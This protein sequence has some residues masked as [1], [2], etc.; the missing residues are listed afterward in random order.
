VMKTSSLIAEK[1]KA[2]EMAL[3]IDGGGG[4]YDEAGKPEYF[5]IGAAEKTYADFQ[6]EVTNAGGHSSAP[7]KVNA[8]NELSAALV[9]I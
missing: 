7:R 5:T 9:K 6:L 8:I 3:N 2:S 1:L 4:L